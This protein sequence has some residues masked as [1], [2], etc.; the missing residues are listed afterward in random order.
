[1]KN[2][3]LPP[4]DKTPMKQGIITTREYDWL[5]TFKS[6]TAE[7]QAKIDEYEANIEP[8]VYKKPVKKSQESIPVQKIIWTKKLFWE[9]FKKAYKMKTLN[10]FVENE[11]TLANVGVVINYFLNNEKFFDSPRLI[12]NSGSTKLNPSFQKGL[13]I[14]GNYGNGKTSIMSSIEYMMKHYRIPGWFK[15][16]KAHELVTKFEGIETPSA[17]QEFYSKYGGHRIYLDDVKKEKIASNYGKV[18]VIR[19]ILEK[20]YDNKAITH[21]T[22]NQREGDAQMNVDDAL[23]EFGERYGGHIYDR[24]F[25]MFNI[26][27]FKGK[28]FRK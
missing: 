1:M 27:E 14:F 17:K 24:M 2:Q 25:E 4:T 12:K 18:D 15:G 20:R 11:E 8:Q 22:C 10:D 6:L 16:S 5:K 23:A 19:E 13:L 9:T 28:S 7:E 21:I 3:N 26:I